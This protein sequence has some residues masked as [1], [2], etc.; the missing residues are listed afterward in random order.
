VLTVTGAKDDWDVGIRA[1][2][3]IAR[4]NDAKLIYSVGHLGWEKSMRAHGYTTERV[5]RMRKM[6]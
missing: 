1:L 6:L 5:L 2:E 4:K 3:T